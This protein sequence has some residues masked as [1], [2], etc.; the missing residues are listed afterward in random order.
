MFDLGARVLRKN[1]RCRSELLRVRVRDPTRLDNFPN[2]DVWRIAVRTLETRRVLTANDP[3]L[4]H[5]QTFL[6]MIA[7]WSGFIQ[8][9]FS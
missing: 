2:F 5:E 7:R 8:H 9:T 6:G 1:L 4:S 3:K